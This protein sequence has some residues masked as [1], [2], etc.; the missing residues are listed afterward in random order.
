MRRRHSFQPLF[1]PGPQELQVKAVEA[2]DVRPIIVFGP[3]HFRILEAFLADMPDRG[4]V[5]TSQTGPVPSRGQ[6]SI[7]NA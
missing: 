4:M 1:R 6:A 3:Q 2:E 5:W 7:E